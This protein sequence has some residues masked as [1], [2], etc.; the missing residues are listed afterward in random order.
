MRL[1]SY[2]AFASLMVIGVAT[3]A[4]V[5]GQTGDATRGHQIYVKVGC[6]QCH[7]LVA[8]GGLGPKLAPKPWPIQ[9]LA[10]YVRNPSREMP[11]YSPAVLSAGDIVDIHAYLV[12]IPP[13]R[14]TTP[15]VLDS[16]EKPRR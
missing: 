10:A 3:L 4:A 6:Y 5:P 2:A 16:L 14:T 13:P 8:Q 15:A 1:A 11:P 9:A 7:G 12:T